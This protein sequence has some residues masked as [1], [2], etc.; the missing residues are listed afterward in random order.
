MRLLLLTAIAI[1]VFVDHDD[2]AVVE[3][4]VVLAVLYGVTTALWRRA[5]LLFTV[6][7]L[8]LALIVRVARRWFN[9]GQGARCARGAIMV[10]AHSLSRV[11]SLRALTLELLPF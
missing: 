10:T 5:E 2:G 8:P 3:L 11:L 7:L 6:F 1:V 9:V 4:G